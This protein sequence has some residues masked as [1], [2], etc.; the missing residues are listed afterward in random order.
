MIRYGDFR[1]LIKPGIKQIGY[2]IIDDLVETMLEDEKIVSEM[3]EMVKSGFYFNLQ[4][5]SKDKIFKG[6]NISQ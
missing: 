5:F 6:I 1:D 2:E 3:R 4:A